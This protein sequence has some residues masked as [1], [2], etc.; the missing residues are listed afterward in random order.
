MEVMFMRFRWSF[1]FEHDTKAPVT[2]RGEIEKEHEEAA[3]KT[4]LFLAFKSKPKGSWRS[5]VCVVEAIQP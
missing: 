5:Y 4:A 3:F 2:V 1:T